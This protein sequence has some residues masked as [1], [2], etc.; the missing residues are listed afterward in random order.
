MKLSDEE[1]AR[2]DGRMTA[3]RVAPLMTGNQEQILM[4]YR[5]M[6]KEIPEEDLSKN[7]QV[8]L[9][10]LTEDLNL[11]WY[12]MV[13][14][15]GIRRRDFVVAPARSWAAATLDGWDTELRCPIECKH[16]GGHEP[17]EIIINRY[18]PQ[19]QWQIY[20][21]G[22]DQCALSTIMGT[23]DP[24]VDFVP[25]A[26]AYI[27]TMIERAD[28]FMQCVALR[29]PPVE[30]TEVPPPIDPTAIVNMTGSNSW[31]M[32]ADQ[33]ITNKKA[34]Q[35]FEDAKTVIKSL[36]VPEAKLVYGHGIRVTRDR[37]LRLHIKKDDQEPTR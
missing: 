8:Q 4:L 17:L 20:C 33:W 7:F 3:S 22:A 32:A 2:R 15:R 18:Q 28:Y 6:I 5:V 21:T 34:A 29:R 26:D 27:E 10:I 13:Q 37:A 1:Q 35:D 19:M 14:Q 23:R 25:R 12:E 36:I 30:L 31:A 11:D 9:G 16:V 24:V